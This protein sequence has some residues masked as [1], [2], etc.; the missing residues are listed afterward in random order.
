[1]TENSEFGRKPL[2]LQRI[3][4][5]NVQSSNRLKI[6]SKPDLKCHSKDKENSKEIVED[7]DCASMM[8]NTPDDTVDTEWCPETGAMS[9]TMALGTLSTP[10]FFPISSSNVSS[11]NYSDAFSMSD[12]CQNSEKNFKTPSRKMEKADPEVT[13]GGNANGKDVQTTPR[14]PKW[15]SDRTPSSGPGSSVK[16]PLSGS[17]SKLCHNLRTPSSGASQRMYYSNYR[18]P[19]GSK[20]KTPS[21]G[22]SN[23]NGSGV[24]SIKTPS[25]G[26]SSTRWNPFDSHN[27]ADNILNPTMSPNVFSIVI[28]PSQES[29]SSCSGRFWSIDQQAEMFPAEISEESPFK[30]SIYIKNHCSEKE[31]KTQEQID[32][33]FAEHHDITSPPDLPPTGPLMMGSPDASFGHC[34]VPNKTS[35]WTQTTLTFPPNLPPQ[36]ESILKQFCT[37]QDHQG[38]STNNSLPHEEPSLLSNSTL[39]RKLFNADMNT[40]ESSRSPSPSSDDGDSAPAILITPG[41][42]LTTPVTCR[43]TLPSDTWSSSPVRSGVRKTSFSPPDCMASPMFSPI[44]KNLRNISNETTSEEDESNDEHDMM[45]VTNNEVKRVLSNDMTCDLYQTA[46]IDCGVEHEDEEEGAPC[47]GHMSVDVEPG[48]VDNTGGISRSV[49]NVG[50]TWTMSLPPDDTDND[51]GGSKVDT[52]YG[53]SQNTGSIS[54]LTPGSASVSRQDSGVV[55]GQNQ[56]TTCGVSFLAPTSAPTSAVVLPQ[57]QEQQQQQ[58][59]V[60]MSYANDNSNDISVGFPLG[61]STPTKK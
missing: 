6:N 11:I 48:P 47:E 16:T 56:D 59:S 12:V 7:G 31:N 58:H 28:S 46:E 22:S 41:K 38:G 8:P 57:H 27:S 37:F 44:V 10:R 13:P 3:L 23:S 60:L 52:G 19:L 33:Y 2:P 49:V 51:T 5:E 24:K 40:S 39:R 55:T 26:S 1:M 14:T 15:V 4:S 36:V 21:S 34:H 18:T 35:A 9:S 61:S 29:E 50:D 17:C 20:M 25:S 45:S 32:L 30:Q 42:L 43:S 54:N 53:S